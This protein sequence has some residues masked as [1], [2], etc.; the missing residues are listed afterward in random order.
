[1]I[2]ESKNCPKQSVSGKS[3]YLFLVTRR[4]IAIQL[5]S[6]LHEYVFALIFYSSANY[7]LV[8][9]DLPSNSGSKINRFAICLPCLY[10][11]KLMG[12]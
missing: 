1:M 7:S 3:K 11:I 10:L 5:S 4:L 8:L 12:Y 9:Q 2:L 6:C